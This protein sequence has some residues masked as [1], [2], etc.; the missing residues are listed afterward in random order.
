MSLTKRL[1]NYGYCLIGMVVSLP[2]CF[3]QTAVCNAQGDTPLTYARQIQ[4]DITRIDKGFTFKAAGGAALK[5]RVARLPSRG[6]DKVFISVSNAQTGATALAETS[7]SVGD[8]PIF[9][10]P[11]RTEGEYRILVRGNVGFGGTFLLTCETNCTIVPAPTLTRINPASTQIRDTDLPL[12]AT[13]AGFVQGAA[14]QWNAP[15]YPRH[16]WMRPK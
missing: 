14:M 1:T 9:S 12:E 8:V 10:I 7:G 15:R 16:L 11:I 4:C 5:F 2:S 3:G 13:G 6:G